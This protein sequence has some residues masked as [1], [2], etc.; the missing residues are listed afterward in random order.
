M[1]QPG[2]YFLDF[3]KKCPSL[4]FKLE[5]PLWFLL[6]GHFKRQVALLV[7]LQILL[8]PLCYTE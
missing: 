3:L 2:L 6:R 8:I 5:L 7:I 1:L 4:N